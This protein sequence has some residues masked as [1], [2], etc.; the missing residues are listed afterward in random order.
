MSLYCNRNTIVIRFSF[1]CNKCVLATQRILTNTASVVV[2]SIVRSVI[3][4]VVQTDLATWRRVKCQLLLANELFSIYK[5]QRIVQPKLPSASCGRVY[6]QPEWDTSLSQSRVDI[7]A[8]RFRTTVSYHGRGQGHRVLLLLRLLIHPLLLRLKLPL[9]LHLFLYLLH[10][11]LSHLA[12]RALA[13][14]SRSV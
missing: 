12:C 7:K 13:F 10:P 5:L 2:W 4:S 9:S 11:Q 6:S 14:S 1:V 8:P 3:R